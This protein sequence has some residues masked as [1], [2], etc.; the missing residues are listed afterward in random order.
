MTKK[1]MTE[2]FSVMLLAWPN[3][4]M[5][6]GGMQK[7]GPTIE[8]WTACTTDIDFW[9][10]QQAVIKLCQEC[11]FT[12]TI[13]EFREKAASITQ[14][15]CARIQS[16]WDMLRFDIRQAKS[17]EIAFAKLPEGCDIKMV[18][19]AMGGP[20]ALLV[21]RVREFAD[22]RKEDYE[23]YNFDGFAAAFEQ[24][25][26]SRNNLV[27]ERYATSLS[28]ASTDWRQIT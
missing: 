14:E 11:K 16:S 27:I 6:K 18:I 13:A 22:G 8:L 1:E 24:L 26:R 10:A 4:E 5:F 17:P 3:A 25:I 7:L 28:M 19:V 21:K 12:P 9:T 20:A 2:I 15:V 23:A